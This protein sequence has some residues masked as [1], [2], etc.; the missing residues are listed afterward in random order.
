VG[1]RKA[2]DITRRRGVIG[3]C[4][5]RVASD[6]HYLSGFTELPVRDLTESVRW[7]GMVLG[8]K[9]LAAW[10][11]G[12]GDGVHLRRSEGQ[13]L[14]LREEPSAAPGWGGPTLHFAADGDLA[15][16]AASAREAGTDVIYTPAAAGAPES[17][18]VADP[19]GHRLRLF[20]RRVPT[21]GDRRFATN[22][23]T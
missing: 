11:P 12:A 9:P 15:G 13:D 16:V 19:D 5:A 6:V 8:F 2:D 14:V 1:C 21:A 10:R 18:A 23:N 7:Y 17:L 20:A 22:A 4:S 3:L